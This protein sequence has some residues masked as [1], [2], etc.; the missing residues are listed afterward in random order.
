MWGV[1]KLNSYLREILPEDR[2]IHTLGVAESAKALAK[3]NGVDEFKAE[4]AAL[5]HDIAKYLPIN[6]QINILKKDKESSIDNITFKVPQVLH[7]YV[8]AILAKELIGIDDEEILNAVRYHTV[9]KEN[10]SKLEKIIYIADYIEPNRNFP[11]VDSLRKITY[12]NLNEGV[13][14]GLEN[15]IIFVIKQREIVHPLT[16]KARNYLLM[17]IKGQ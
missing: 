13:L 14:S 10:M 9:G 12:E 11:G 1:E 5:V 4:I 2:Y 15:T 17:E 7:G 3:L 16:V 8:G 6:E